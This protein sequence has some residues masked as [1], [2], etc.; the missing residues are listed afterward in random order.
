MALF[1][2]T[3]AILSGKPIEVFNNGDM[4]RDFTYIDDIVEGIIRVSD[5]PAKPN[6][7]WNSDAPDPATSPAPYRIYNIGNSNPVPLLKLIEVLEDAL[8]KKAIKRMLP[9]QPGDVRATFANVEGL[10]RDVDFKPG[11]PIEK[12]VHEFVAWY[13]EFYGV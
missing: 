2:F 5:H 7:D 11:T 4:E 10:A 12:G 3:K 9:I 8:G 6:P 1:L 13:R